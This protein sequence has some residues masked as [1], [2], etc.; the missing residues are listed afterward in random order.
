MN[1]LIFWKSYTFLKPI[2]FKKKINI[3]ICNFVVY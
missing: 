2:S 1:F 3:D